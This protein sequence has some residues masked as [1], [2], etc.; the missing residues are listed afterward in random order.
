M[1]RERGNPGSRRWGATPRKAHDVLYVTGGAREEDT[2]RRDAISSALCWYFLEYRVV[3]VYLF[4]YLIYLLL[5][6][7][8]RRNHFR[9]TY[10][11]KLMRGL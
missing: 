2:D 7:M 10:I 9:Y 6:L 3:E 4:I 8:L 5:L 11:V 1:T